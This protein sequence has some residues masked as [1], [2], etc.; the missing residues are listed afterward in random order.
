MPSVGTTLIPSVKV[1]RSSPASSGCNGQVG[2][3]ILFNIY[4]VL[5]Y[6]NKG[7]SIE[8]KEGEGGFGFFRSRNILFRFAAQQKNISRH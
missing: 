8:L 1:I 4:I 2:G 5:S 6:D 3:T 7:T